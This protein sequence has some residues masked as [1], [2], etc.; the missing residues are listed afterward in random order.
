MSLHGLVIAT[1]S[2]I[3][4]ES[5]MSQAPR[6]CTMMDVFHQ[7]RL[8]RRKRVRRPDICCFQ[9]HMHFIYVNSCFLV[10]TH[11]SVLHSMLKGEDNDYDIRS[12]HILNYFSTVLS[13]QQNPP[14]TKTNKNHKRC[15]HVSLIEYTLC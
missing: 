6:K 3:L 8:P 14:K 10:I 4:D 1:T 11:H 5:L 13:K 7:C 9:S 15:M 12:T 2:L